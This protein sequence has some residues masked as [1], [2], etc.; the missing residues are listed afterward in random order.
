MD[1]RLGVSKNG[2]LDLP[3]LLC[4]KERATCVHSQ[5]GMCIFIDGIRFF[6]LSVLTKSK[7]DARVF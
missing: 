3:Q 1:Q 2:I 7:R 4:E 6:A 5:C